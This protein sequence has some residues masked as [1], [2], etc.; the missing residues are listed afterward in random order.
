MPL[1]NLTDEDGVE[2]YLVIK[3][4][5]KW[6]EEREVFFEAGVIPALYDALYLCK[7][8]DHPLPAWAVDGA[9][10]V[11]EERLRT[12]KS[13]GKGPKSNDASASKKDRDHF[14]RWVAVR[15]LVRAGEPHD[16][17]IYAKAKP[18]LAEVGADCS[19]STIKRSYWIVEKDMKNPDGARKYY[20]P[21]DATEKMLGYKQVLKGLTFLN[22]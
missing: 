10:A 1:I 16:K 4:V 13:K 8:A 6:L 21:L 7:K 20:S 2:S 18:S 3:D 11:I 14:Q 9:L 12:G 22:G 5:E 19:E 17:E 15:K